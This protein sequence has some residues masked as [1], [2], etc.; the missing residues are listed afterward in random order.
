MT[1]PSTPANNVFTFATPNLMGPDPST[2]RVA[3]P[4][5][6]ANAWILYRSDKIKELPP[7]PPG[8]PRRPQ[9]D[10]SKMISRMWKEETD[11]VKAIY[12]KR[13]ELKKAE[14]QARYPNY[15]FQPAKKS[16]KATGKA[17][18]QKKKAR[19]SPYPTQT[20]LEPAPVYG[21][22][23]APSPPLS[24]AS[25]APPSPIHDSSA[26]PLETQASDWSRQTYTWDSSA[27]PSP[28]RHLLEQKLH[29]S[30]E[31]PQE[32]M[33]SLP[34]RSPFLTTILVFK[35]NF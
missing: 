31:P 14:H 18:A 34:S 25:S 21:Y 1:D 27:Q 9:S 30:I 24:A 7:V 4:P 23:N 11:A 16:D 28:P 12:E 35:F 20:I 8:A 29:L 6:P 10:V 26:S 15:R 2:P 5:R 13:A 32:V 33:K 17:P 22:A 19:A 3:Q